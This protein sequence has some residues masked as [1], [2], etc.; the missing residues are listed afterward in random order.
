MAER[1]CFNCGT[2]DCWSRF[3]KVHSWF[4]YLLIALLVISIGI[5]W[6]QVDTGVALFL[7]AVVC[8]VIN[9]SVPICCRG[10]HS[11]VDLETVIRRDEPSIVRWMIAKGELARPA[12]ARVSLNETDNLEMMRLLIDGGVDVNERGS[13]S[14]SPLLKAVRKDDLR[15]ARLLV[16][17]GA[18]VNYE[19]NI[20][21]RTI[22]F[23]AVSVQMVKL[24][25]EAGADLT[26][27][28]A[29]HLNRRGRRRASRRR[30]CRVFNPSCQR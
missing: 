25:V 10:Y 12:N 19:G 29:R 20:H 7:L 3:R 5:M 18:D 30:N 13:S 24:L 1:A 6:V 9:L 14:H 26:R 28:E 22:I 16:E 8:I 23:S 11:D 27:M 15:K 21:R 2:V 4:I 17:H